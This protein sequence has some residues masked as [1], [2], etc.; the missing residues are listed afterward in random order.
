MFSA[1][2]CLKAQSQSNE[3]Q[4]DKQDGDSRVASKLQNEDE[5]SNLTFQLGYHLLMAET[6][7]LQNIDSEPLEFK[8]LIMLPTINIDVK[9]TSVSEAEPTSN[10]SEKMNIRIEQNA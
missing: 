1:L 7:A 9:K 3:S 8:G 10:S 5:Y 2:F 6:G 4:S